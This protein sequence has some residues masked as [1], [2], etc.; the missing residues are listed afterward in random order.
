MGTDERNKTHHDETTSLSL[1]ASV[2]ICETG[3]LESKDTFPEPKI[4]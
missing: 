3:F 1:V 2:C 4:K